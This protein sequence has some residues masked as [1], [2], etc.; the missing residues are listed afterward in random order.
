MSGLSII[1]INNIDVDGAKKVKVILVKSLIG[2]SK[3]HRAV[4]KSLGLK[5]IGSSVMHKAEASVLGMIKKVSYLLEVS[6]VDL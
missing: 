1:E 2:R 6:L 4:V 3:A 5:K